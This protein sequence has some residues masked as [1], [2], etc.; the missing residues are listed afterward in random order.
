[1][2]FRFG[3]IGTSGQTGYKARNEDLDVA[4]KAFD[5]AVKEKTGKGYT[6]EWHHGR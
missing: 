2:P 4:R 5:K 1:M 3:R 6:E